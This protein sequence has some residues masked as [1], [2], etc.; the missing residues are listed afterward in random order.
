[1]SFCPAERMPLH[2]YVL[3]CTCLWIEVCS[4]VSLRK[5]YSI[6]AYLSNLTYN[7]IRG[8]IF[9]ERGTY[10]LG[11]VSPRGDTYPRPYVPLSGNMSPLIILQI[12]SIN[13][14]YCIPFLRDTRIYSIH[15]QVHLS[16]YT[17]AFV[18]V[19]FRK[20]AFTE[21]SR[22]NFIILLRHNPFAHI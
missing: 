2:V 3:K 4:C 13:K 19:D 7:M 10:G 9:L 8:D 14:H 20:Q 21:K 22:A 17:R 18:N 16:T 11:N 12:G 5:V 15:K 6:N 1:M